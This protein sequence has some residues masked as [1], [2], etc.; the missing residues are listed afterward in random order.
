MNTNKPKEIRVLLLNPVPSLIKYGMKWGF[1]QNNCFVYLM[2]DI[3]LM[4]SPSEKSLVLQKIEQAIKKYKINFLFTEGYSNMPVYEIK[5]LCMKY[6]IKMH[7][8]AIEDPVT[9]SIGENIAKNKLADFIWTT[10][11][12]FI[13]KY[14]KLGVD[15]DLLLFGCNPEFQKIVSSENRFKHDI[16]VVGTNYSSRY[17]KTKE[18]IFPLIENNF[19]IKIYGLWWMNPDIPINLIKYKNKNI[20]WQE[21]GYLQLPYEWLPIVIN[22]SKIMIGLNCTDK[23]VTQTSC[24]PF[25]TLCSAKDSIYLAYYTE[26]QEKLFGDYIVQAKTGKE[27][28]EKAND[29]LSWSIEKRTEFATRARE[30]VAKNHNYAIRAKTVINRL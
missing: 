19:D 14:K 2:E 24:R 20:Y 16:S 15:S 17:D 5:K 18:F 30:Y 1:E 21:D 3:Y 4:R 27:M 26:A 23:S 9:P 13:D 29:I 11:I 7:W 25:E 10:T 6:N 22:S 8:W 28:I 12:E